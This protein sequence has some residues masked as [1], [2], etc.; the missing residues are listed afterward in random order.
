MLQPLY[1]PWIAAEQEAPNERAYQILRAG[2]TWATNVVNMRQP[3]I[4]EDVIRRR[5]A[6]EEK[7]GTIRN[8]VA[9]STTMALDITPHHPV[10]RDYLDYVPKSTDPEVQRLWTK[11]VRE[12][13]HNAV[14]RYQPILKK[15]GMMDQVFRFQDL[16]ALMDKLETPSEEA[17]G[18]KRARKPQ[19]PAQNNN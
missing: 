15:H 6:A 8:G 1:S 4:F 3:E 16:D 18:H 2:I 13:V 17:E 11:L 7:D 5:G 14:N 10:V 19:K 12:P 9:A